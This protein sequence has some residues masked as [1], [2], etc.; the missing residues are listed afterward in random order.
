[1][2]LSLLHTLDHSRPKFTIPAVFNAI[3]TR[4]NP[5]VIENNRKSSMSTHLAE[6]ELVAFL[7]AYARSL[8]E[9]VLDEIWADCTTFLKDV[10]A[11]PFPHRQILSR[12]MEFTVIL[13]DKMQHTSFGDDKR[14]KKE[15]GDLLTR[16]LTAT[17]T[18]KPLGSTAEPSTSHRL[19]ESSTN[20]L[21]SDD[22]V[23]ILATITPGLAITL[24]DN[25]RIGSAMMNIS[26]NIISPILHSRLFPQNVHRKFLELLLQM[27]KIPAAN[28]YF[29][30]DV[31]DA[32]NDPR[33]FSMKLDLVRSHW[34]RILSSWTLLEKERLPE[35]L[36]RLPQPTA[37][38]MLFGVGASAARLEADRKV[39]LNLRRVALL[40][41]TA[42]EDHFSSDIT[43]IQQKLED[44]L[45]ATSVSSPSSVTRAEIFMLLRA[46][47]LKTSTIHLA[48]FW[49][50]VND[51]LYNALSSL[52]PTLD[53]QSRNAETYNSYSQLQA[54]KL[55][56]TLL[57][58][59]PDDFQA[60]A[61]LFITDTI[62]AVYP[63]Q[64]SGGEST[65]LA[66]HISRVFDRSGSDDS[67]RSFNE[68]KAGAGEGGV[69]QGPMAAT[70]SAE[71]YEN[72]PGIENMRVGFLNS[73]LTREVPKDAIVEQVLQPFFEQL[74][75][76]TFEGTY[77]MRPVDVEGCKDDLLA[78]LFNEFTM[79]G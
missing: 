63:W 4:T 78:D 48:P 1:M 41:L 69:T 45:G 9:D 72:T 17:F 5:I 71:P 67:G 11:N 24:G 55:L 22:I 6:S 65:A 68:R 70:T 34:L 10:L 20:S 18:S 30:K 60:Q 33:F 38:G 28:R 59:S 27:G 57:L 46:L 42:E 35:L 40:V 36:Q 66:D 19:D 58:T 47:V 32:F 25:D 51:E 74:S 44:L 21:G 77:S 14:A 79:A 61:W 3:Y 2:V 8:D 50:L 52:S 13:G 16:L 54:C 64:S 26:A 53:E 37:A 62:D 49:P 75:I 29:K 43:S 76:R 56:E 12:L 39:Q 73:P 23:S 7:V 15:L 31:S